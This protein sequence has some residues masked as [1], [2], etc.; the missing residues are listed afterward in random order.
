[1]IRKMGRNWVALSANGR[2]ILGRFKSREEAEARLNDERS[3]T[4]ANRSSKRPSFSKG[5]GKGVGMGSG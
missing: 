4:G 3:D 2:E 5:F 1:M